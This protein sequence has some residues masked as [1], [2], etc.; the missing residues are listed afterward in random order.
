MQTPEA[1][2]DSTTTVPLQTSVPV[3]PTGSTQQVP[4]Q[5][6]VLPAPVSASSRPHVSWFG[7]FSLL[8]YIKCDCFL[9]P[10][11]DC[12]TGSACLPSTGAVCGGKQRR[13]HQW[14][15]VSQSVPWPCT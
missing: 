7:F 5:P 6:Q 8:E 9:C 12:S 13:L 11:A 10:G 14:K 1:G 15:H 2:A 3:Q 4:V